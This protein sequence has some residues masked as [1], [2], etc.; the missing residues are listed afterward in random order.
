MEIP[1]NMRE[2]VK[3]A[4]LEAGAFGPIGAFSTVA[5]VGAIAT[6]W[7]YLLFKY[8]KQYG[9][10]LE[11]DDA[12]KICTT[13]LLG[14]GGYYA[15]CKMAT[16]LFHIIPGAGT[17]LAMGISSLANVIFTYR[18]ALA[19][20]RIFKSPK[21]DMKNL[22]KTIITVFAGTINAVQNVIDIIDLFLD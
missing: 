2:D 15:G 10:K 5:D 19:L 12:V 16:K 1:K 21:I 9:Y 3:F 20:T 18:F 11:K 13:A 4:I 14:L 8:T 17:L 6:V 7:G 22:A